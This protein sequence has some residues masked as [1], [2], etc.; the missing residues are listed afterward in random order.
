MDAF[1]PKFINMVTPDE[2][3]VAP[4]HKMLQSNEILYKIAYLLDKGEPTIRDM[5]SKVKTEA[6]NE[7]LEK[8][9][10]KPTD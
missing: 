9:N 2:S 4:I 5:M 10:L 3:G 1:N 7:V 6:K 8:L